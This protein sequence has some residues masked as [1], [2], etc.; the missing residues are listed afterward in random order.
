MTDDMLREKLAAYAHEAWSGWMRLGRLDDMWYNVDMPPRIELTQQQKE[1]IRN[2]Y[3]S[4]LCIREVAE[5]IGLSEKVVSNRLKEWGLRRNWSQAKRR[6][7]YSERVFAVDTPESLYWAG[8]LMAD[9]N[10]WRS[11]GRQARTSVAVHIRDRQHLVK[12]ASFFGTDEDIIHEYA[13]RPIVK[14]T[15]ASDRVADDLAS[16]GVVP[17]KSMTA[18]IPSTRKDVLYSRDFWRGVVDGDGCIRFSRPAYPVFTL[19]S[20]SPHLREQFERYLSFYGLPT[21]ITVQEVTYTINGPKCL[22]VIE[23]LY[24]GASTYL[25]RKYRAAMEMLTHE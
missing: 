22:P 11:A 13:R 21:G 16:F 24:N 6:Y 7:A 1:E 19:T 14:I 4:G 9:G 5:R 15:I 3:L 2:L 25:E 8:F 10:I 12:L 18:Q 20:A 23:S 17:R